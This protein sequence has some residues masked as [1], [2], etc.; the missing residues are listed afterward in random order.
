[1]KNLIMMYIALLTIALS[2]SL[3]QGE[4]V[5]FGDTGLVVIVEQSPKED[6]PNE[7]GWSFWFPDEFYDYLPSWPK[8]P[9]FEFPGWAGGGGGGPT[10]PECGAAQAI[11]DNL[12]DQLNQITEQWVPALEEQTPLSRD[13]KTYAANTP[14][15]INSF[16]HLLAERDRIKDEIEDAHKEKDA[17][18]KEE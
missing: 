10:S 18:C 12:Y 9:A 11:L 16:Y 2:T 1:M 7:T 4:P 6:N 3:A 15:W 8:F 17:A 14:G 13:G 5:D